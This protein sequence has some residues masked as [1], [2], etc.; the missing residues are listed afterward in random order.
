MTKK[1]FLSDDRFAE[2]TSSEISCAGG[3]RDLS[4]Q[5]MLDDEMDCAFEAVLDGETVWTA[6]TDEDGEQVRDASGM[7]EI[8]WE[9][10]A[11][12]VA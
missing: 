10:L 9:E 11:E 1:E 5:R 3:N 6:V 12:F 8:E 4:I 7:C 2:L